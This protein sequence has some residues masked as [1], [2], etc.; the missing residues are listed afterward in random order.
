MRGIQSLM[1]SGS[2]DP[3]AHRLQ[4][5]AREVGSMPGLAAQKLLPIV[6]GRL[7]EC[8]F[9]AGRLQEAVAPTRQALE[10]CRQS[11]DL[12]SVMAYLGNL[13]ELS[14]QLGAT[15]DAVA[16][17]DMLAQNYEQMG[18]PDRAEKVR[19]RVRNL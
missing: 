4:V 9:R 6:L 17:A 7:G 16:I 14:V 2:F 1:E 11:G 12:E 5:L 10:L 13:L 8:H 18:M 19:E 3:A 15:V